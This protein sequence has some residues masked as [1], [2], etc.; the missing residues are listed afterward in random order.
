MDL[1][2][3]E[4]DPCMHTKWLDNPV[5]E[6]VLAANLFTASLAHFFGRASGEKQIWK[7]YTVVGFTFVTE[8]C[9]DELKQ[10]EKHVPEL[11]N[12]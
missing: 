11:Q 5:P 2:P 4:P 7:I 6:A 8:K 9:V 1:A 3:G 12:G 10:D